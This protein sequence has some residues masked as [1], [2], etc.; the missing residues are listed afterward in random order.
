MVSDGDPIE[1]SVD[2]G[3]TSSTPPRRQPAR[4]VAFGPFTEEGPR[5]GG[6][7]PRSSDVT[8]GADL[9][10]VESRPSESHD[11][12]RTVYGPDPTSGPSHSL[13]GHQGGVWQVAGGL[14]LVALLVSGGWLV[15]SRSRSPSSTVGA[16]LPAPTFAAT[17]EPPTT[18]EPVFTADVT[19]SDPSS[20]TST[21]IPTPTPT[22]TPTSAT[23][24]DEALLLSDSD[25]EAELG[26]M[27]VA[28]LAGRGLAPGSWLPQVSAKCLGVPRDFGP[29]WFSEQTPDPGRPITV[30][31]ILGYHLAVQARY[32]AVLVGQRSMGAA[33]ETPL[34]GPCSGRQ[35]WV[36][37][38]PR[39]YPSADQAN[40][41]CAAQSLSGNQCLA[42]KIAAPGSG[43]TD[44]KPRS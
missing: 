44:D 9:G 7:G 18:P 24:A 14:L 4:E 29:D 15:G 32:G 13:D 40:A 27:A 1:Y 5:A 25:A 36:S 41:W 43:G 2:V 8:Y 39:P 33:Q 22:P 28:D 42:R 26:T 12:A 38:V 16:P 3:E 35:V 6:P 30:Q 23:V 19:T 11:S 34:H 10:A 20:P 37:L 31:Q 17:T 21:P